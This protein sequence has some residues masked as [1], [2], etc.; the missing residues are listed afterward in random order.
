[1][2]LE[3]CFPCVISC[4]LLS[5]TSIYDQGTL[6]LHSPLNPSL[7]TNHISMPATFYNVAS[8]LPPGVHFVLAVLRLISWVFRMFD[9]FLAVF[10]GGSKPMVLLLN[11]PS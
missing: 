5:L 1:M 4:V 11:A 10:R 3:K 9:I 6:S 8:S 2:A 7:P